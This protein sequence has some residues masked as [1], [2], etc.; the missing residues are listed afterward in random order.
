M[1]S[2]P[3]LSRIGRLLIV[4]ALFVPIAAV[5]CGRER[6]A[7]KTGTDNNASLVNLKRVFPTTV[8]KLAALP[9]PAHLPAK[10]RIRPVETRVYKV[11]AMLVDYK[12]ERDDDYH[13]VLKGPG[14]HTMIAEIP[15]PHCVGN[16]SPLAAGITRA[17]HEFDA[18]YRHVSRRRFAGHMSQ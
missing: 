12:E 11:H 10:R 13:L 1:K 17:R 8:G 16:G 9:A 6:W 2:L 15:A 3:A 5:A 18:R 4:L 7:V 14:G